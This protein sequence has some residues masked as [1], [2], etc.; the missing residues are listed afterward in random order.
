VPGTSNNNRSNIY[1]IR[2]KLSHPHFDFPPIFIFYHILCVQP[3]ARNFTFC[4][5]AITFLVIGFFP[6][7][8]F[9]AR[10][11]VPF[12]FIS[13]RP[14][15]F[16]R[17]SSGKREIV[18]SALYYYP[19][20]LIYLLHSQ[21]NAPIVNIPQANSKSLPHDFLL[22]VLPAAFFPT[23]FHDPSEQSSFHLFWDPHIFTIGLVCY[24]IYPII[25]TT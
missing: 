20:L 21:T 6:L 1:P 18:H 11:C 17:F 5:M 23:V 3:V 14:P 4:S 10:P 9:P 15:I 16:P 12:L 7:F 19:H 8:I 22:F 2:S 25:T 24:S 13:R